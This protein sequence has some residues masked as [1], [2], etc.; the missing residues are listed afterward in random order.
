MANRY[1]ENTTV[2]SEQSRAEIERTLIRYGASGF[3]YGWEKNQALV[4]FRMQNRIVRFIVPLPDKELFRSTPQRRLRR[5]EDE[6]TR[7]WEKAC[8]QR[9]RALVLVIKAKLEA[10]E[11]G[12]STAENEFLA[13]IVLPDNTTLGEWAA[14]Q[15]EAAYNTGRMPALLPGWR[16]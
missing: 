9:W 5:S 4:M 7:E 14:P 1:A 13:N 2:S 8:R 3:S 11:A 15:I 16:A 6:A 12:I 10:V